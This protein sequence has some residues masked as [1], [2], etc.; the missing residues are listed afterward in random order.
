MALVSALL[1]AVILVS[2]ALVRSGRR[3]RRFAAVRR[4]SAVD[5]WAELR[6]SAYDLGMANDVTLTPQQLASNLE[7]QL[8]DDG[9]AALARFRASLESQSFARDSTNPSARDLRRVLASLRRGAGLPRAVGATFVPLSLVRE[10]LP[11]R[12]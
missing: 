9:A 7:S 10:W 8:D 4:G 11:A 5:G 12:Q 3:A 6:D 1:A 2:P